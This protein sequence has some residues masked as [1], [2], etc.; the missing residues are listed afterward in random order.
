MQIS[1]SQI[2]QVLQALADAGHT[3]GTTRPK[4]KAIKPCTDDAPGSPDKTAEICELIASLPEVRPERLA[5]VAASL[6][7]G[8]YDPTSVEIAEKL[9]GR[10][11]ADR[12]K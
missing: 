8:K 7:S 9:L 12:L 5:E 11:L 10:A 1:R 2:E 6:A 3:T 4:L